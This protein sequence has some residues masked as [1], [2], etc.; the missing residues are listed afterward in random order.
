MN[1]A[2]PPTMRAAAIDRFGGPEVLRV[3]SL[4][5]PQ[6]KDH[7]VLIRL[8]TAGVA[9]WD[10]LVRSGELS[11]GPNTFP[12]VIGTDGAGVVVAVGR[13]VTRF[14]E[15]D[16]VYACALEGGFYAEYV[17]LP[18]DNVALKPSSIDRD[19]AGALGADAITA[20]RGLDDQLHVRAGER[21]IIHGASGGVG[22]IAVQLAKRLGA[23]VLAV[24]SGADG[25]AWCRDLGA[26][27]VAD[28]RRGE[29][30]AIAREFSPQGYDA[31]LVL[32]PAIDIAEVLGQLKPGS[33]MAYPNGVEPIPVAPAHVTSLVYDGVI[34]RDI[35]DRLAA[36]IGTDSFRVKLWRVYELDE[37][38]RA[39]REVLEHHVG[40]SVLRL[41]RA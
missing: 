6:P 3:R 13:G 4:P 29:A 27:A 8:K 36:V 24:A 40:K 15:G 26:D 11:F 1:T 33:R 25:V 34:G 14:H 41:H 20:L 23:Q 31:A 21:I 7:E 38:E 32:A 28:G 30:A 9:S 5:V 17:A 10:A 39:H 22:H 18:E 37:A 12:F 16:Q 19:E 2:I 35:F